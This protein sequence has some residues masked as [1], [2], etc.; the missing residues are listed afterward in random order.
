VALG[1][2]GTKGVNR[3]EPMGLRMNRRRSAARERYLVDRIDTLIRK[4]SR[5]VTLT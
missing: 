4:R 2:P 1:Y 5:V 3:E